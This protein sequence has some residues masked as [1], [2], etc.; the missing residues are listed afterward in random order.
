ML[1]YQSCYIANSLYSPFSISLSFI[2]KQL[3]RTYTRLWDKKKLKRQGWLILIAFVLLNIVA[4]FHA[5]KFTHFTNNPG[6]K[7]KALNLGFAEKIKALFFEINNPR[8]VNSS[9][10]I[11]IFET[12]NIQSNKKIECWFLKADSAKGFVILFHGYGG[13]KSSMLDKADEFLNVGYNTLVVD[14]M[15]SGD[16]RVINP[17]SVSK[18]PKSYNH[19]MII[20]CRKVKRKF[21]YLAL[22]LE[23]LPF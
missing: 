10:P 2:C 1:V 8:P 12:V 16:T 7:T 6:V 21:I 11:W 23:R 15:A 17:R 5:Y 3:T 19:A 18:K 14:F 9:T 22:L 4:C 20:H 13:E